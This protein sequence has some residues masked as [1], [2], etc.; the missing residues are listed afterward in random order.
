MI[1]LSSVAA[2]P[3][4]VPRPEQT[5]SLSFLGTEYAFAGLKRLLAAADATKAGDRHAG[6][7][8]PSEVHREAARS[9]LASLTLDHLYHHPLTDDRG[10]VDEVM[11]VNYAV[12]LDAFGAIARF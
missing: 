1:D 11:R 10:E 6:L 7:A 5:Y 12:D 3:V 8:A 9:I 4:P 2:I